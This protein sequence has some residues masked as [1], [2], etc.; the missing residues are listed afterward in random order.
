MARATAS[1]LNTPQATTAPTENGATDP[2][3]EQEPQI[4]ARSPWPGL[5]DVWATAGH[6]PGCPARIGQPS[7][8]SGCG[9]FP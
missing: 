2:C 9:G 8:G 5:R 6:S 1:Q 3:L 7:P 4:L